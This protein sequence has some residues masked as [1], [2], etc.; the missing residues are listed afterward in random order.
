MRNPRRH[1]RPSRPWSL[2][3]RSLAFLRKELVEILRQPRLLALLVAG[4]FVLLLLF[5]AGYSEQQLRLRTI[6]V[7]QAGSVYED[8]LAT[9]QDDLEEL[10][11][12]RGMV[13]TEAEGRAALQDGSA[14]VVVVFP[15]DPAGTVLAGEQATILVIHDQIDPIQQTAI[16]IA[17][18]MAIQEVNA[19]VLTSLAT[20]ARSSLAPAGD[21][22]REAAQLA[23]RVADA[24]AQGA[25]STADRQALDDRLDDL[26]DVLDGSI[27][28]LDRLGD[29]AGADSAGLE[30]T[31][32]DV[33][34]LRERVAGAESSTPD[35]VAELAADI[36]ALTGRLDD[37]VVLEPEVLIRPF[38]SATENAL[39]EPINPTEYFTPASLALLLQH[40]AITFASL[41]LVRDRRGGLF[42]LMRVGPLSSIEILIGKSLAYLVLGAC[43]A[44]ALVSAAVFVLGVPFAG[45]VAWMA[46]MVVAVVLSSLALGM[47]LSML[48][49]S[50]S[51]A[52]QFA[53]LTLLAGLFFGGFILGLEGLAYPVKVIS[54]LLPVTY[55]IE[56]FQ[57][58]MLRGEAPNPAAVIGVGAITLGYGTIAI[59]SLRR[60]LRTSEA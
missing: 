59:V 54:W 3:I 41:S 38:T 35:D 56:A 12:S 39:P 14:D 44:G 31:R 8:V 9:Y 17:A 23:G 26:G 57:D 58:V 52:V 45:S 47:V 46:V 19:T 15:D 50:E 24:Y 32:A 22:A 10:V 16:E 36:Q 53:M 49:T 40:L 21:V 34:A 33:V 51:Q 20:D 27:T 1:R 28:V 5:G 2:A 43:V 48:S 55:G 25:D 29:G 60:L 4:P 30:Q 37:S 42:E 18:Q 6:F 13:A 11:E 7:G